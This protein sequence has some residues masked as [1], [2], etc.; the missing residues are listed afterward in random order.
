VA[1]DR[2][3]RLVIAVSAAVTFTSASFLVVEPLYAHHVLRRPPS[4]FA[5]FEAA[6]GL[7]VMAIAT[8]RPAGNVSRVT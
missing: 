8:A 4:Q 1:R 5:L 2:A 7:I 6:A 3:V